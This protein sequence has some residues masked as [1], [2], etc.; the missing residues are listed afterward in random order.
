MLSKMVRKTF[1]NRPQIGPKS[2]PKWL[3]KLYQKITRKMR[4]KS[5]QLGA[6]GGN[7][8]GKAKALLASF[9]CLRHSWGP[10]WCQDLSQEPLGLPKPGFLIILYAFFTHFCMFFYSFS[11]SFSIMGGRGRVEQ[12]CPN[13]YLRKCSESCCP[14][15]FWTLAQTGQWVWL[16]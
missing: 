15:L 16:C 13:V 4:P 7:P 14:I 3:P 2:N 9:S 6:G 8:E 10:T 12:R 5:S 1:K 11:I